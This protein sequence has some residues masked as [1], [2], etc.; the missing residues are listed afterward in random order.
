LEAQGTPPAKFSFT[1]G[2][3]GRNVRTQAEIEGQQP[4]T[5]T[6]RLEVLDEGQLVNE[7]LQYANRDWGFEEALA[8]AVRMLQA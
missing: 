8:C 2:A 3:D 5:R 1:R 4:I 7:E 6:V